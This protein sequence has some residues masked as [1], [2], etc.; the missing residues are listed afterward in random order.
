MINEDIAKELVYQLTPKEKNFA[1]ETI[2]QVKINI[3]KTMI[4][5]QEGN[6]VEVIG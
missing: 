1:L 3:E 6:V 4:K 5:D 2:N